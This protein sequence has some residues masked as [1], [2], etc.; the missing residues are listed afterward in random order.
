MS[1][2]R[3]VVAAILAATGCYSPSAQDC[4]YTCNAGACP[5]GLSCVHSFCRVDPQAQDSCGGDGGTVDMLRD[6]SSTY[7]GAVLAST[8]T[9]YWRLGEKTNIDPAANEIMPTITG[10][11]FG[12]PTVGVPGA[13]TNDTNT[14][15]QLDQTS[16][17]QCVLVNSAGMFN[18]SGTQS[19]SLEAWIQPR[20]Q[21]N[22]VGS[23][24]L[25]KEGQGANS[26]MGY[27]LQALPGSQGGASL[28]FR[29]GN[30][31]TA[32][33]ATPG[34][35]IPLAVWAHVVVTF[36]G[37]S[38][39]LTYYVNGVRLNSYTFT[40][41][42]D[43]HNAPFAIGCTRYTAAPSGGFDGSIDEVAFYDRVVTS[44]EVGAHY[45]AR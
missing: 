40:V 12:Q 42:S 31:Q 19:L 1:L 21:P 8:P 23:N 25:N 18:L 27:T 16:S 9:A 7:A 34:V 13:L 28:R 5:T 2:A 44:D 29:I 22:A 37:T 10:S 33:P 11:Y 45:A 4:S 6:A 35:E 30:G 32:Q 39:A 24:V 26:V 36:D 15:V 41:S 38:K 17:T 3:V 43:V 20:I 14:A